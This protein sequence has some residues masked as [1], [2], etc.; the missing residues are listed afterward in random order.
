M[1][2]KSATVPREA[3]PLSTTDAPQ[4]LVEL[5]SDASTN[6]DTTFEGS[7]KSNDGD[8]MMCGTIGV[9]N[10]EESDSDREP[11]PSHMS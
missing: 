11:L 5:G 2:D 3:A 9:L 1:K 6:Y 7:K 10:P 4:H 8:V